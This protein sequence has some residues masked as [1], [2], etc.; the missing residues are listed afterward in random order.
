VL[1]CFVPFRASLLH[2]TT[3]YAQLK[4]NIKRIGQ[5]SQHLI[6]AA[7]INPL[8]ASPL[9]AQPLLRLL[10]PDVSIKCLEG[11]HHRCA[12]LAGIGTIFQATS[13][14]EI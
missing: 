10:L 5:T 14:D 12:R 4:E 2:P 3:S 8:A 1:T 9:R 13:N 11:G 6:I 7:L